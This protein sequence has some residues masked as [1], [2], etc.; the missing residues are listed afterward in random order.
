M[1]DGKSNPKEVKQ[2]FHS[3]KGCHVK[4]T[5]SPQNHFLLVQTTIPPVILMISH[6][7]IFYFFYSKIG[8]TKRPGKEVTFDIWSTAFTQLHIG[9]KLLPY[10]NSM[11]ISAKVNGL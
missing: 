3:H 6:W 10:R 8:K 5:T 9:K 2:F 7:F 4:A 11:V 1:A